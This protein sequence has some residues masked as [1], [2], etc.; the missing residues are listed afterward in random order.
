VPLSLNFSQL[1]FVKPSSGFHPVT[2]ERV[3][4]QVVLGILSSC[5]ILLTFLSHI[6][7]FFFF[8]PIS[9]GRFQQKSYACM[10]GHYGF[11]IKGIFSRPL[12]EALSSIT[13]ILWWYMPSIYGGLCPFAFLGSWV[14]VAPYLCSK[15]H[16]FYRLVL[17][18]YV[19]HVEGA[20]NCFSHA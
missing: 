9:F 5:V 8:L 1:D 17:E 10:W 12:N 4:A 7:S 14:L 2:W 20:H 15:F 16:I 6:D 11:R 18:K 19:Y 13:N 3:N